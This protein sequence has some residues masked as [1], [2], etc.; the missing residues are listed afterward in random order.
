MR[1]FLRA[2]LT[3]LALLPFAVRAQYSVGNL[4]G[5]FGVSPLGGATYTIPIETP[6]GPGGAA[7]QI[8]LSY[9]S[10]GGNGPVGVGFNISGVS[11]ITRIGRDIHHD[12]SSQGLKFDTTD[13][14]CLDG[15]RL[16][17]TRGTMW[18]VGSTYSPENDPFTT[19]FMESEGRPSEDYFRVEASDGSILKYKEQSGYITNGRNQASSSW[20]LTH[21]EDRLG[22]YVDYG[23]NSLGQ[24]TSEL[25]LDGNL[26]LFSYRTYDLRGRLT[27]TACGS[28]TAPSHT[29]SY[30]YG[31]Q[32]TGSHHYTTVTEN[33][34]G[35]A[36]TKVYDEWG[37]LKE[38]SD[39]YSKAVYQ[40]GS[41]GQPTQ[42][43]VSAVGGTAGASSQATVT[44]LTYDEFGR[45]TGM[46]DPD[47][48]TTVTHY[49]ALGLTCK[50]PC[51]I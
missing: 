15:T 8:V 42:I 31:I 47:G 33:V 32:V 29:A 35:I 26:E 2:I 41:H 25:T 22:N 1:N 17:L 40:Y 20:Y 50:V 36:S 24:V 3:I 5:E 39:A 34:D 48:G 46:S 4:K 49:D 16:V 14:M 9:N 12:G 10:Q 23:Y 51:L 13:A 27:Y 11:V 45:R 19:V 7:P 18:A 30:S 6:P 37:L 38:S 43:T 21:A 44:T 28:P